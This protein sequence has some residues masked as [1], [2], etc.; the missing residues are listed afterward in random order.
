VTGGEPLAQPSVIKLMKALCDAGYHVSLETG[1]A[2]SIGEVDERVSIVLDLKTPASGEC[3]RNLLANIPLLRRKDQVKFVICDRSD[4]EWS[5]GQLQMYDL[6]SRVDDVLF[7]PSYEELVPA[8][9]AQWILEDRLKVRMQLQLHKQI[10]GD[11]K[12]V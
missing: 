7:S 2:M 4:Y 6:G 9:L 1:G 3:D 8:Q 5:K 11:K 10:W 12:G